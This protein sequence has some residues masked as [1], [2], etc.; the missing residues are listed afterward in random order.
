MNKLKRIFKIWLPFAVTVTAFCA[1]TYAAI[2]QSYRQ[3]ADDPQIQ[4]AADAADALAGGTSIEA[5]VP[6]SRVSVAKSL[7]PFFVVYDGSANIIA[8]SVMLDGQTPEL[9]GGVLDSAKQSGENR[10]TWQPKEG[11][12]I[13]A[14][15]V[16]YED[17]YVL[18][19]RNLREVELREAQLTTFTGITWVLAMLATLAV[20]T[21]GEYFLS[22]NK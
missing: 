5:I 20:I 4:M 1:L 9:P 7:A 15:I 3:N 16:P 21:F 10:V 19:G 17:G 2:Q 13:A 6:V 18:A 14:V 8:S 12:R 22:E 11:V